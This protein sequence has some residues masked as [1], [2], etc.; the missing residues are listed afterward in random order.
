MRWPSQ[1]GPVDNSAWPNPWAPVPQSRTI[2]V[3]SS[4]RT[5][6]H[7]VLPPWRNVTR[8]GLA[9]DPRVPQNRIS[10]LVPSRASGGAAPRTVGT[11]PVPALPQQ[12]VSGNERTTTHTAAV[13]RSVAGSERQTTAFAESARQW[14]SVAAAVTAASAD[15]RAATVPVFNGPPPEILIAGRSQARRS[16]TAVLRALAHP[17]ALFKMTCST[18]TAF[19]SARMPQQH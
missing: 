18:F 13:N 15:D 16:R 7:D 10:I 9:K 6:T 5:S 17:L 14:T 2:S 11:T 19:W 12:L 8:P 1:R 4:P 3:P